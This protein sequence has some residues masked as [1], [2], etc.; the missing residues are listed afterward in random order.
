MTILYP[1]NVEPT[2]QKIGRRI[3]LAHNVS[4]P[5]LTFVNDC[6]YQIPFL[7]SLHAL[8]RQSLVF[9]EVYH[10]HTCTY[11]HMPLWYYS[12]VTIIH[13]GSFVDIDVQMDFWLTT[14]MDQTFCHPLYS[15]E[16]NSL[17]FMIYCD[18]VEVCNPLGTK[19]KHHKLGMFVS[20]V[21]IKNISY[22]CRPLL[23][24]HW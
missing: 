12:I 16:K 23:L 14:V 3:A 17:Q 1:H 22:T 24:Y 21:L 19:V 18:D 7:K 2:K 6:V 20:T 10:T 15:R 4:S 5:F 8:L 13:L 9:E 11:A